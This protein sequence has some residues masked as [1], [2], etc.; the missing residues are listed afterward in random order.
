MPLAAKANSLG[1]AAGI[2]SGLTGDHDRPPSLVSK[3][4]NAPSTGSLSA[5]PRSG[6]LK[7]MQ[8]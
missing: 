6:E 1:S 4:R 8:S 5:S 2:P 3:S 7:A